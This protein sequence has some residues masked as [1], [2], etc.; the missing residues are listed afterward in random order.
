VEKNKDELP[1]NLI[2]CLITG[3]KEIMKIFQ[4]KLT[5]D[6]IIE[7]KVKNPKDKYLG[8]K[9][10]AEMQS[11]MDELL[12]CE[13]NFVRCIKPNADKLPDHWVEELAL[14]QIKYLGVL[15]SIKVR[16]ESL[17]VR[18]KFINFYEKYQD[19][20]ALSKFKNV[21]FLKLADM[22]NIDWKDLCESTLKSITTKTETDVLVGKT[23]IFMSVNFQN[24]LQELLD[25]K[26][27]GKKVAMQKLSDSIK[28]FVFA[29]KWD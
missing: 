10:R 25:Q 8:Y 2:S 17:P 1:E 15:D 7:E 5:H 6:E 18:R 19:L 14:K 9:F 29:V 27:V 11:L 3:E 22:K 21:S 4:N 16:R 26:Q 12:N 23:R 24:Y 28:S 20:D 13:C